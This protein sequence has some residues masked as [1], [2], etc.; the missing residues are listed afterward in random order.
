MWVSSRHRGRGLAAGS[1]NINA[2]FA[3]IPTSTFGISGP[4]ADR[5]QL[6]ASASLDGPYRKLPFPSFEVHGIAVDPAA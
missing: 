2:A 4:A 3:S 6:V 5:S 1:G